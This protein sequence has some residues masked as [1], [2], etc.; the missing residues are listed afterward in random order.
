[1]AYTRF[2]WCLCMVTMRDYRKRTQFNTVTV[3]GVD[4]RF[5]PATISI[6]SPAWTRPRPTSAP[7]G[8]T[9]LPGLGGCQYQR[10]ERGRDRPSGAGTHSKGAL[11]QCVPARQSEKYRTRHPTL[12]HRLRPPFAN[13]LVS[14]G[15]AFAM[16][17]R[18][19]PRHLAEHRSSM[20]ALIK[21]SPWPC[22][23]A[24]IL[25]ERR[26]DLAGRAGRQELPLPGRQPA[27]CGRCLRRRLP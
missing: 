26:R 24:A 10:H 6:S 9:E 22:R 16:Q 12:S 14:A 21:E 19:V 25:G 4:L 7:A 15:I 1:M 11:G 8:R 2:H 17:W 20:A 13:S 27:L 23:R 5:R 3:S 18:P